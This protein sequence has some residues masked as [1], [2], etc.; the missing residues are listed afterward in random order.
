MKIEINYNKLIDS[1]RSDSFEELVINNDTSSEDLVSDILLGKPTC[2]LISGYRGS[3]KS[4][5]INRI[6][7]KAE[8]RNK[9]SPNQVSANNEEESKRPEL[10]FIPM[11]FSRHH[12]QGDLLRRMIRALYLN[13]NKT[14]KYKDLIARKVC[15]PDH[16]NAAILL[17]KLYDK[18]FHEIIEGRKSESKVESSVTTRI[19]I[20]ALFGASIV[21]VLLFLN[22][23]TGIFRLSTIVNL[24]GFIGSISIGIREIVKIESKKVSSN[25][26][27]EDENR[28]S[29]YDNEIADYYLFRLLKDFYDANFK[30]VF[31]LDELDKVSD[32]D[33]GKLIKELKPFLVSGSASF[34]VV[35]GQNLFYKYL[36]AKS[37]DDA[38]L[39]SIFSRTIHIRLLDRKEFYILFYK[40]VMNKI[41]ENNKKQMEPFI[42]H[43]IFESKRVPRKFIGLIRHNLTYEDNKAFLEFDELS[44]DYKTSTEILDAIDAVSKELEVQGLGRVINDYIISQLFI[45]SHLIQSQK[46]FGFKES[47]ILNA[48]KEES[49]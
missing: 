47:D 35:A 37:K 32:T 2:Y 16:Q 20:V 12:E 36:E 8:E 42:N 17:Q 7:N 40:L 41:D 5:F 15:E 11:N 46:E 1:P 30:L 38:E 25:T 39:S 3:G 45:K 22:A 23:I 4:T 14:T 10:V 48:T 13:V 43:L 6:K 28:K 34:I 29:L 19:D 24:I 26:N 27:I 33:I 9:K 18:T 31:V 21:F 44:E 49:K